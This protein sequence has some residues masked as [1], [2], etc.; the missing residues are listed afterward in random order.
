MWSSIPSYVTAS[1]MVFSVPYFTASKVDISPTNSTARW[2][3]V[4]SYFTSKVIHQSHHSSRQ[5]RWSPVSSVFMTSKVVTHPIILHR[6][7]V[8]SPIMP[9]SHQSHH[10]SQA[11]WSLQSHHT[12]QKAKW[13]PV[14]SYITCKV[15]TSYFPASKVVISSLIVHKQG[16]HFILHNKQG[17]HQSHHTS[18]GGHFSPIILHNK[19]VTQS[20]H[21][22]QQAR[23]H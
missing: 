22:S 17:G 8:T 21:T 18:E 16:G 12:S 3:P 19:V 9:D 4:P 5:A 15:V 14:P 2:S 13:S 10:T 11:R 20:Q 6:K 7:V 1:K 23:G